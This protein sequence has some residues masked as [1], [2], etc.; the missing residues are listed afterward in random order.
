[1]Y[2]TQLGAAFLGDSLE[3][4]K[5]LTSGSV[6]LIVTSQP[7]ALHFQKEYGNVSKN[8]YI[9]WFLPFGREMFRVLAEDGS[10]VLNSDGSYRCRRAY[11]IAVPPAATDRAV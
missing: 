4:M 5:D 6:Q 7:Y 11:A 2:E 9:D 1:M 3:L 10:L 8:D